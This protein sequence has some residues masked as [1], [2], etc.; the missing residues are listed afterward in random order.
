MTSEKIDDEAYWKRCCE[1]HLSVFDVQARASQWSDFIKH[2]SVSSFSQVH[3]GSYKRLYLERHLQRL[4]ET[5]RPLD[6]DL[7]DIKDLI[8]TLEPYIRRLE[9][10]EVLPP[11]VYMVRIF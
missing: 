3:G 1:D 9:V 4:L 2:I 11:V 8:V 10:N 5:F 6:M 7:Y